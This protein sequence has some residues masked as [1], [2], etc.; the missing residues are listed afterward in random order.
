ME[1]HR[2]KPYRAPLPIAR[3][4]RTTSLSAALLGS[5]KRYRT[6]SRKPAK[7]AA[8]NASCLTTGVKL[9]R[10]TPMQKQA[11]L[12]VPAI[13][14]GMLT[15][16]TIN[17]AIKKVMYQTEGR[18]IAG[19][20]E[21]YA[22]PWWCTLIM[23][24]GELMCLFVYWIIKASRRGNISPNDKYI[25]RDPTGGMGYPRF[26]VL[27]VLLALCDL[28]QTTMT[29][30]GLIYCPASI[31]QILRGFLIVFVLGASRIFLRRIPRM[32]QLFGVCMALGGLIYVGVNA[33][34]NA[35]NT[36]TTVG[37][38]ALGIMLTLTA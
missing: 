19:G 3:K 37:G 15:F 31:T 12:F 23:F 10:T 36:G 22:K 11:A 18:N 16:G 14:T 25:R 32:F 30:I 27:V 28:L 24:L 2:K 26:C 13:I 1:T 34:L 33:M 35:N 38:I 29:G 6:S 5:R 4:R 21:P 20:Y 7:I 8:F 9:V 17:T